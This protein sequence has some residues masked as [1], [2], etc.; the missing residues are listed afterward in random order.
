M[1]KFMIRPNLR[2]GI[3]GFVRVI[4]SVLGYSLL[5]HLAVS[6]VTRFG[7]VRTAMLTILQPQDG[8][9]EEPLIFSRT[10]RV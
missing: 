2:L 7:Q 6:T 1:T 3:G 10:N 5:S 9:L 8:N 4:R